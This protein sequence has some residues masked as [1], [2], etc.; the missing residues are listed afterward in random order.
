IRTGKLKGDYYKAK[1]IEITKKSPLETLDNGVDQHEMSG[2]KFENLEYETEFELKKKMV[3]EVYEE[4]H[5][6]KEI[7]LNPSPVIKGYRNKMEYTFGDSYL[8]GPLVLGMHKLGKFYEIADYDGG[9]IVNGDFNIIREFTQTFF[10]D[11]GLKQYHKTKGEGFLKFFVIKYSFYENAFMLNLVTKSGKEINDNLLEIYIEEAL[12]LNL[13]GKI[14]SFFHTISDSIADAIVP[15]KINHI[16]GE[17]HLT[18]EING[19]KFNISPFSFFQPNPKGAEKL[20]DR[21]VEFAGDISGK[22]VFDLYS[23]TGTISQIFAKEASHVVG[24]E[25]VEEA[26]QKAKE[27]AEI[28]NLTNVEFRAND[29]LK[30]IESLTQSPDIVIVDPPRAGI[31]QEAIS[32]IAKMGANKI[33]YISCNPV[34]QVEDLKLFREYKYKIEKI[35]AFDQFPK[36]AH[37]ETVVLLSQLKADHHIEVDLNLDEL[38][39]TSAETKATYNEIQQYVLKETGLMVSNL[40]IAQVKKKCGI[41]VG[42]SFN[43]PKSENAKQPKC[44]TE[45]EKAIRDALVH[46]GMI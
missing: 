29:V 38:D 16:W 23:G 39:A 31:H 8:G 20:Y 12:Q 34:T 37:V 45:K 4:L 42:E 21:A 36:T 33:I 3:N 19:L 43:K 11:Q 30:E 24:V 15:D 41:E 26:V 22:T 25:I 10:R 14:I 27:N 5:W 44:P 35:E 18:E 28:N 13:N 40:Y 7:P 17:D 46:F 1:L 6:E 32:K 9:S 2:N